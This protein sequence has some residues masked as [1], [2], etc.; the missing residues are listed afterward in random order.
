[1]ERTSPLAETACSYSSLLCLTRNWISS[2]PE[3]EGV[4]GEMEL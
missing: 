3:F 1:M 4:T 2:R